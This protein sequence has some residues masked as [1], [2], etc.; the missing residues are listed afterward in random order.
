MTGT[1]TATAS[2]AERRFWLAEMA[3]PGSLANIAFG[4]VQVDGPVDLARLAAAVNAV[5]DRHEALRTAFVLEGVELVRVVRADQ[6]PLE[7]TPLPEGEIRA[8]A[9]ILCEQP[10]DLATGD[11]MRV[12][13]VTGRLLFAVHHIAFDG[14]SEP[15]F[16]ADLAKAYSGALLPVHRRPAAEQLSGPRA[17]ALAEYWRR[18]LDGVG[19]LPG[20]GLSQAELA[21]DDLAELPLTCAV[22]EMDHVRATA[23]ARAV[24]PFALLLSG[25]GGALS[26]R[27]GG[28]NFCVGTAVANRDQRNLD[29]IGA[30][31]NMVPI[32]LSDRLDEL[33]ERVLDGMAQ[34]E[35]P[36]EDIVRACRPARTRR[37]PLYQ[38]LFLLQSWPRPVHTVDAVRFQARP[39]P[40]LGPQAEVLMEL[41]DLG[42][43]GLTGALQAP[44]SGHWA[45]QLP[46]LA[47]EFHRQ[48]RSGNQGATP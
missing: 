16:V 24:S 8:A 39:V 46:R 34:A 44:A 13:H 14:L 19:D 5:R 11:V 29:E 25:F 17:E 23:A 41:H 48:L 10:M 20:D 15:V 27:T 40:P 37:M 31:L 32:R 30:L 3:A 45:G 47:D 22:D 38:A 26:A 9:A 6:P 7:I 35:L 28:R 36:F 1:V 33:W 4:E 12:G 2:P 18:T 21:T 43:G 42:D